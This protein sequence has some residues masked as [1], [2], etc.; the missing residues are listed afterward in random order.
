M[1]SLKHRLIAIIAALLVASAWG[2]DSGDDAEQTEATEAV[3]DEAS[4]AGDEETSE[5][6]EDSDDADEDSEDDEDT[7]DDETKDSED[8][9]E[10]DEESD[11]ED[12]DEDSEDEDGDEED[13]ED[14]EDDE[15]DDEEAAV[16]FDA[17]ELPVYATGTVAVVDGEQVSKEDFN[18]LAAQQLGMLSPE[19][20]EA[21]GMQM[22]QVRDMILEGLVAAVLIDREIEE[23]GI[24]I[25]D[26]EIDEAIDQFEAMMAQQMGGE[27]QLA[28]ML[29]AQGIDEALM[30]QQVEQELAAEKLLEQSGSGAVT[31]AQ[32]RQYYEDNKQH[33][34]TEDMTR[35]RHILLNV[36]DHGDDDNDDE[37]RQKAEELAETLQADEGRFAELAAEHSDC[38]SADHGG[39]LGYFTRDMLM[40]EFTEAAFS[41]SAGELSEPVRSNLGWHVIYVEDRREEGEASFEEVRDELRMMLE[42]Q[43]ME[44]TAVQLIEGLMEEADVELRK[45]NIVVDG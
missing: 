9:S 18:A 26:A 14:S 39:D 4:E 7:D 12:S 43:N 37:M 21:Q 44:Q 31:D 40:P 1:L 41:M 38:P 23:Q 36:D 35:A 24:Q 10:D 15:S 28:A 42:A 34:Q 13:D 30:R 22:S 17:T 20:L 3:D 16:D 45:E 32:V 33:F 8:D 19:M 2:C 25:S 29:E 6:D 27:G 11:D 5:A